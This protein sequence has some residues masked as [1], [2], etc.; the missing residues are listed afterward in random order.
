MLFWGALVNNLYTFLG[1][2]Q[3]ILAYLDKAGSIVSQPFSSLWS[4]CKSNQGPFKTRPNIM[5]VF[6]SSLNVK[7][8]VDFEIES[9]IDLGINPK[10]C[11]YL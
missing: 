6:A 11:K 4:P 7:H 2:Q 8:S 3:K 5:S 10:L 1:Q 9:Q